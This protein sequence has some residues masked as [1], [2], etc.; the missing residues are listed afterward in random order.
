MLSHLESISAKIASGE[1][2]IGKLIH[3]QTLYES[4][5]AAVEQLEKAGNDIQADHR[6]S[7]ETLL[8]KLP[9]KALALPKTWP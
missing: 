9:S 6:N 3:E 8:S 4:A 1:G 7:W 2:T 5:L